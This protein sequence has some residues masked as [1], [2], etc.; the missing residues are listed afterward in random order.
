MTIYTKTAT[1]AKDKNETV[2][3]FGRDDS[4]DGKCVNVG[5]YQVWK[6]CVNY[7]GQVRG[8]LSETWRYVEKDMAYAEAVKLMNRRLKY[9]A[10]LTQKEK[11]GV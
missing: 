3:A 4:L 1:R 9:K 11:S 6:L 5:G 7:D 10:F 2:Y 8:G